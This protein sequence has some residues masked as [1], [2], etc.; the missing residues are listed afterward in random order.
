MSG[1]SEVVTGCTRTISRHQLQTAAPG[2]HVRRTTKY[3]IPFP[4][5]AMRVTEDELPFAAD[6]AHAVIAEAKAAGV[7][8]FGGGIE[9]HVDPMLVSADGHMSNDTAPGLVIPA[10]FTILE[11][12]DRVVAEEWA[13]KLATACHCA[14]ELREFRYDLQS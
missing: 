1:G 10:G 2:R 4:S 12:P 7:Y 8:V 11:L 9:E 6:E 13:R 5:D 14:Q 3:L